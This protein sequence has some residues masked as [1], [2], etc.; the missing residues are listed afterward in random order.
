MII[1][2]IVVSLVVGYHLGAWRT[3]NKYE[4]TI[5]KL[6][7]AH[8]EQNAAWGIHCKAL[9]EQYQRALMEQ[10]KEDE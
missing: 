7:E 5:E 9:R 10:R 4:Q 1:L 3:K 8:R 2:G 6:K